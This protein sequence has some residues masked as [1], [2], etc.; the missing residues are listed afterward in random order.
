MKSTRRQFLVQSAKAGLA[1]A[2]GV[3]GGVGLAAR[4]KPTYEVPSD[5]GFIGHLTV[6]DQ[7]SILADFQNRWHRFKW[8]GESFEMPLPLGPADGEFH[9]GAA[10]WDGENI[11]WWIDG[12]EIPYAPD[13]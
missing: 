7:T 3:L 6:R 2:A 4:P 10:Q 12:E 11:H 9:H 13:A 1:V 5:E 8:G